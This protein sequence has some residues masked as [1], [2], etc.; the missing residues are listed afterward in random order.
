MQQRSHAGRL[1]ARRRVGIFRW[2]LLRNDV[3]AFVVYKYLTTLLVNAIYTDA[4][5]RGLC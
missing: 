5:D 2:I 4:N 1:D 3:N